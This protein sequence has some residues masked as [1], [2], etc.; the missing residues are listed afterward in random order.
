MEC[1][2]KTNNMSWNKGDRE[3]PKVAGGQYMKIQNGTNKFRV[4][5]E[6]VC[7]YEAWVDKK[8]VRRKKYEFDGMVFDKSSYTGLPQD[9]KVFWAMVVW[10]YQEQQIMILSLDKASIIRD[11]DQLVDDADWG[12]PRNYDLKI[13]KSG[14]K[15]NTKYTILPS[16]QK[17]IAKEILDTYH[18]I[19]INLEK[20]F[21]GGDPFEDDF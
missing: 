17:P 3:L 13:E 4:L 10:N 8:P 18:S 21:E 1:K 16:N 7:G 20:L 11:F 2:K 5:S 12:D 6:P 19:S 9:P 15:M 14:E